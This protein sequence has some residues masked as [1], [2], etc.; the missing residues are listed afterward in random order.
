MN[1]IC[2]SKDVVLANKVED[3]YGI[4][5]VKVFTDYKLVP[6][7]ALQSCDVMIVDLKECLLPN[8]NTFFSPII[9]LSALPVFQEAVAVLQTGA[10][11]YGNRHMR[12]ENLCQAIKSVKA[13]QI[14]L[15]PSI[16]LTLIE[17]I[18]PDSNINEMTTQKNTLL[19]N[20]LSKR[21]QEV[22][23]CVAKGMSNQ[24]I[25]DNIFI[26]IRTVKAHLTSIY[27]KTGLRNRLELGLQLKL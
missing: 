20:K 15:P 1:I 17:Q 5:C 16:V 13:G 22:A 26:S 3:L 4:T 2:L 11:G 8:S 14:W 23:L 19:L 25:A 24:E 12:E 6:N 9:A 10:K 18:N 27:E 21:E 7:T